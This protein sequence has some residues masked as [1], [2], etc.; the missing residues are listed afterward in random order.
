MSSVFLYFQNRKVYL[1]ILVLCIWRVP[2]GTMFY[3]VILFMC[4]C[5]H[6]KGEN[7]SF[8]EHFI[9]LVWEGRNWV[10]WLILSPLVPCRS[11]YSNTCWMNVCLY[12]NDMYLP[13]SLMQM[14]LFLG[15]RVNMQWNM[16][17][18]YPYLLLLNLKITMS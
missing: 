8:L 12:L 10:S 16:W 9:S 1:C 2:F 13:A 17:K 6:W 15:S 3:P 4:E 11:R 5:S 7:I 18:S 14:H